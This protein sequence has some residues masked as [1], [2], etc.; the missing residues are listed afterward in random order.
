MRTILPMQ[1]PLV[2]VASAPLGL[3]VG[4]RPG[5]VAGA[6]A[7]LGGLGIIVKTPALWPLALAPAAI[8]TAITAAFSAVAIGWIPGLVAQWLG[9]THVA[10]GVIAGV[11]ATVIAIVFAL[12]VGFGLAQ[13]LSGFALEKIV[14]HVEA[15]EGV[16]AWPTTSFLVNLKRSLLLVLLLVLLPQPLNYQHIFAHLL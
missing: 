15:G 5:L 13:P 12:V 3:P 10:L 16:P 9:T 1:H 4:P 14:H 8:G 7:M 2:P 6:G 11:L